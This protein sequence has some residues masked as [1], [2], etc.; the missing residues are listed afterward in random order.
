MT[1]LIAD[2][3][4]QMRQSMIRFLLKHMPDHH[5]FLEA[6]D[7]EEA[8]ALYDRSTPDWV[9]MDVEMKPVNGLAASRSIM[10][11]H[12]SARIVIV[13]SY[14]NRGY[15]EAAQNAGARAYIL[16]SDLQQLIT[17]MSTS[18]VEGI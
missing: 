4:T 12:P 11:H 8:V 14:D 5:T 17:I 6:A 2:D 9:L 7:G 3:S 10:A 1:I 16:K 18:H 13:T 15:R